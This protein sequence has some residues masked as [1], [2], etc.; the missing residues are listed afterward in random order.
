MH[1]HGEPCYYCGEAC[2]GFAGNPSLWPIGMCHR[3]DPGVTKWHHTG[4]LYR[5]VIAGEE[6]MAHDLQNT[7]E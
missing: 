3:E 4:C 2:N 5:R 1:G 7:T 6:A